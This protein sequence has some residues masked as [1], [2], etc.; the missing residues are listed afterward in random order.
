MEPDLGAYGGAHDGPVV[1]SSD[2][3]ADGRWVGMGFAP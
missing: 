2:I 1:A 3:V